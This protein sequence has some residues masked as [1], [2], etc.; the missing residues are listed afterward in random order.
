MLKMSTSAMTVLFGKMIFNLLL[1]VMLAVVIIP[2]YIVF[3]KTVPDDWFIFIIALVGGIIGLAGSTTI[4]AAIVSKASIKGALFTVLSF[5]VLIPL[6]LA[7]T[8]ITTAAFTGGGF[9]DIMSPLKLLLA[10][11]VIMITLSVMLFD[12]V[13]RI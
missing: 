6:L 1:L 8:E 4:I 10:Y 3:L 11:D 12:F 13:W 2:L 9:A 7:L 5:P